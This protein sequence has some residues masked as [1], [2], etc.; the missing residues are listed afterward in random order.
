MLGKKIKYYRKAN[1]MT[2]LYLGK[3]LGYSDK[4]AESRI[5]QYELGRRIPKQDTLK[6]IARELGVKEEALN[7]PDVAP[8]KKTMQILFELERKY[9][10][11]PILLDDNRENPLIM[12]ATNDDALKK[13]L[14]LWWDIQVKYLDSTE[15]DREDYDF[16]LSNFECE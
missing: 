12:L 5:A 11:I 2:Q 9:N 3:K 4:S 14:L 13:Q 8:M 16:I 15:L 7:V 1:K 10:L 6:K